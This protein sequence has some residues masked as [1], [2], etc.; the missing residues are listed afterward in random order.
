M[1]SRAGRLRAGVGLGVPLLVVLALFV[2]ARPADRS[3]EVADAKPGAALGPLALGG[4]ALPEQREA[5]SVAPGVE[6]IAIRRGHPSAGESWTLTVGLGTS[7][8][9]VVRLE[10]RVREAGYTP[11]R[12]A[13]NGSDPTAAGG[14]PLG[15]AVRVGRYASEAAAERAREDLAAQG[16]RTRLQHTAVD[17]AATTGP[18]SVN[19]LVVDP[20]A[21]RGRLTAEL[22]TGTVPGREPVSAL[23][24]RTGAVA[25]ING[26]F[27]VMGS[28][29]RPG[30]WVA[31]TDGDPAGLSVV[32]GELVSEAVG[33]RPALVLPDGSGADAAVLRLRTRLSARAEG[34][35]REIT[36]LNR[37]SG[38]V[39]NCGAA[40]DLT[41]LTRPAHDYTCGNPNELVLVTSAFGATA[42]EGTGHQVTVDGDGRVAAVRDSRGGPVPAEGLLLQGTGNAATWLRE[43][44][45]VGAPL[46]IREEVVDAGTGRVLPMSA[47]TSV[48]N[49]GPLLLRNGVLELDPVRDGW[50]PRAIAGSDRA[51]F[52]NE[53]YLRRNART[54]AGVTADG[55]LI[56][57]TADG[58]RPGHSVGLTIGETAEVM[59]DLGAVDAVNLDG[60]GSTGMVVEK[61]LR[62]R[63]SDAAG[64][65]PVGDAL[66]VLP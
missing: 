29:D 41:P 14:T 44:A 43:R 52:Y 10:Q 20:D 37:Q 66:V 19:V 31:G 59:R 6:H 35:V 34:D 12:S 58:D 3:A 8:A 13:A 36:G 60:G 53:W 50:S 56:L 2:L 25:G 65:R 22:A 9:E 39:V 32:R 30:P 5:T 7:E 46:D 4:P 27:F 15:H 17:G 1:R 47:E 42:P 62:S 28:R 40:G 16:I 48:I 45:A 55:R 11:W 23:V 38:L 33:E 21:F 26:G 54:A 49:G 64:E 57:M 51:M 63:P 18:W 24:R 61:R